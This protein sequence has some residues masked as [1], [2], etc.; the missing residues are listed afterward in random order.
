MNTKWID[1]RTGKP[2]T[3]V[4]R[5]NYGYLNTQHFPRKNLGGDYNEETNEKNRQK[6]RQNHRNDA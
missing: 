6:H 5:Y 1:I 3:H 4:N 2:V